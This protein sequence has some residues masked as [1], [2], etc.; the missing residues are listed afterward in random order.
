MRVVAM[1]PG[2]FGRYLQAGEEF[3]V[4]DGSRSQWFVPVAIEKPADAEPA[5]GRRAGQRRRK[6]VDAEPDLA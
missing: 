2:F 3:D 1:S 5:D 6:E 4:P